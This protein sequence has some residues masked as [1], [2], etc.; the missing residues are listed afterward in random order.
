MEKEIIL[1]FDCGDTIIDEGTEIKNGKD[2]AIDGELIPGSD[3]LIRI[4][5]DEGYTMALV[6]DGY[7]DTFKNLLGKFDLYRYFS[8]YAISEEVGADKP[9]KRMFEKALNELSIP[10]EK[11]EQVWMIGNNLERD[12]KGANQSGLTS[13]WLD[14]AP[15]RSKVPADK[16]EVPDYIIKNPLELLDLLKKNLD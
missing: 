16:W 15:R 1:F 13:V 11:R 2:V 12:I 14:W 5:A 4:L 8:S 6:A 3:E 9:D 10:E 7:T